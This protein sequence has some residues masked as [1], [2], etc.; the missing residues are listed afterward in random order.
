M[1][2]IV[3]PTLRAIRFATN[4][5]KQQNTFLPSFI[6]MDE[7]ESRTIFVPNKT[8]V[9]S[10]E[11]IFLLRDIVASDRFTRLKYNLDLVHFFTQSD[12]IF[13]FFEE[14]ASEG[15]EFAN[16]R[17]SDTYGEFDEHIDILE[18][19]FCAYVDLLQ[20]RDLSDKCLLPKEYELNERFIA[21]FDTI[22]IFLEGHLNNFEFE[23]IEK[24]SQI[25]KVVLHF[26]TS[27]Y[28]QKMQQRFQA[29]GIM[30]QTDMNY[31][32][33]FQTKEIIAQETAS[34][35]GDVEVFATRQRYEQFGIAFIEIQKMVDSGISPEHIAVVLPDES[36]KKSLDI[37]DRNN[38]LNF[39][40]GF[41][42]ANEKRYKALK[43][44]EEFFKTKNIEEYHRVGDYGVA[45]DREFDFARAVGCGDFFDFLR[46]I[47]LFDYDLQKVTNEST[48]Q[49]IVQKYLHITTVF[50]SYT[51]SYKEWLYLWLYILSE[52]TIDDIHGGKITVIGALESRCVEFDGLIVLDF[53]EGVIPSIPSKDNFLNSSVREFASL[54]TT[55]DREALQK[56]LYIRAMQ[57]AKKSVVV[58]A[59]ADDKLPSRFIYELGLPPP[60]V[61]LPSPRLYYGNDFVL[62]QNEDICVDFDPFGVVWSSARLKVFLECKRRYYY[63]YIKGIKQKKRLE[64]NEGEFIHQVLE[65]VFDGVGHFEN[66][67]DLSQ[68]I[69]FVLDAMLGE[70]PEEIYRKMVYQ[71]MLHNFTAT[72]IAHFQK[73]WRVVDVEREIEGS[74]EG[75]VFRG[76]C[77]RIDQNDTSTYILDYKSGKSTK[78]NKTKS[79]EKLTDFQMN[80]YKAILEKKYKNLNFAFVRVFDGGRFEEVKS[81]EEKEKLFKATLEA[82]KM[83]T[84]FINTK[85]EDN[86]TCKYCEFALSCQ[87]G[88][89]L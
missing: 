13:K 35:I 57:R 55:S 52:I 9:D 21:N 11:R 89:Y 78:D 76:R 19:L 49:K 48:T 36:L 79:L 88:D 67:T 87:R 73:G 41:D 14:L 10:Y 25:T 6:P 18:E 47:G 23:I 62:T 86:E 58:Y 56:Q 46:Q 85:C 44:L 70:S 54:P 32:I 15:V 26:Q 65:K 38:N 7:F 16:L 28:T 66:A 53:N 84:S 81:F 22:E 63:R 45:L 50:A 69:S 20:S 5:Y 3:Y 72:Q 39:A 31:T 27:L 60:K 71:A 12:V 37:F 8:K 24:V 4:F 82:L 17:Y 77:D 68:K 2:L 40:M 1:K 83:T 51:L 34:D 75:L 30:L 42:Y 80:I 43:A 59:T 33:N 29:H 64:K 61:A 74:I